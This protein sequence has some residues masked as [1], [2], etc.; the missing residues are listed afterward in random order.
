MFLS[1]VLSLRRGLAKGR[2]QRKLDPSALKKDLLV[3]PTD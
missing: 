1:A 3:L 2:R